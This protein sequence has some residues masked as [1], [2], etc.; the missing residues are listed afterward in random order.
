MLARSKM[1]LPDPQPEPEDEGGLATLADHVDRFAIYKMRL[2]PLET[3]KQN[4]RTHPEGD[5]LYHSLQV[6]E[7]APSRARPG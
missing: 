3:V 6:F 1:P 5:A 2:G 7:R 4:P